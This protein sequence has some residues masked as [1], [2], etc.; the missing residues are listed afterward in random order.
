MDT[1]GNIFTK[2]RNAYRVGKPSV[3]APLSKLNMAVL[4]VLA[5]EGYVGAVTTAENPAT[6]RTEIMIDLKY[7]NRQPAIGRIRRV[8]KPGRRVYS[9]VTKL[10]RP[11]GGFGTILVS[12]PAGIVTAAQAHKQNI[13][14]EVLCEIIRGVES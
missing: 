11:K 13:G 4:R 8:S 1:L 10:P 6:G 5:K 7:V 9:G 14:G 3:S 2:I 12:T